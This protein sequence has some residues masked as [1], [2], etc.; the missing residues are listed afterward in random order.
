MITQFHIFHEKYR[1][2]RS[3]ELCAA[4][5]ITRSSISVVY[6]DMAL[7]RRFGRSVLIG[8]SV[9]ADTVIRQL[10]R[11]FMLSMKEYDIPAAAIKCI[12]YAAP[13]H[14]SC[15][16][17]EQLTPSDLFLHPETEIYT[18]PYISAAI[19]GRFTAS[20]LA[21]PEKSFIAA[22]YSQSLCIAQSRGGKITCAAVPLAGAFEH[23]ALESGMPCERGAI[24]RVYRE[25]NGTICYSV[26]GDADSIGISSCAAVQTAVM[27]INRGTVDP[28]G[29]MTDRDLFYI[30]EDFFISQSD[31]RAIQAD[32]A[33]SASALE[34][35]CRRTE[36]GSRTFF[37]GEVFAGD[38]FR[39]MLDIGAIPRGLS[40][41]GYCRNSVEQGIICCLRDEQ[42]RAAADSIALSAADISAEVFEG[43]DD[44][45]IKNLSF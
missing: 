28:D 2:E 18:V 5:D 6:Y 23:T 35:F 14:L 21:V 32:K 27:M 31:V 41:A 10:C 36:Q 40:G 19:S 38:G 26:I 13:V 34:L 4:C 24:E 17:E 37:S 25:D 33:A 45:Y 22:D 9:S 30:G 29:I 1:G 42:S 20:L 44:L 43:F 3:A 11:L 16:L 8:E 7:S 12:G 15:F 39:S